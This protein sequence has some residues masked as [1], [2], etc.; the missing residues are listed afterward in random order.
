MLSDWN[1][2]TFYVSLFKSHK[3]LEVKYHNFNQSIISDPIGREKFLKFNK[4]V[5]QKTQEA[6]I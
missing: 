6:Y 3:N 4:S 5:C 2:E 1:T